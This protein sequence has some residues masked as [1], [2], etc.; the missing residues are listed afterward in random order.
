MTTLAE[1][2]IIAVAD[3]RPPMLEKS[4][5]DS[6]KCRM[7]HYMENRE[8]R[9]MILNLVQNGPLIW[10]TVTEEDGLVVLMFNQGD[11]P[12]DCLN[13]SMAFLTV[14]A[15][16]SPVFDDDETLIL[17]EVLLVMGERMQEDMQGLLSAIIVKTEDLD[18]YDSDCD[19]VS[20]TKA[21]LMANLSNYSS[22]VIL[23]KA[24][25]IK[26]T[27]Y[28]GSVISKQHVASPV[29]DDDETLILEETLK[30]IFNVF[31][32]DLLNE[33]TEVQT[34]FNQMEAAV[35]HESCVKCLNLDAKLLNKENEYN[36]L[37]KCYSQHEKHCISLE[38]TMKLNQE[39]FQMES[40]TNI[41]NALEILEY[42]ENNELKAQLQAK[43]TTIRKLKEH[44]KT[45]REND[46]EEKVK[47]EM[48]EIE[49]IN[50]ELEH[51]VAKLLFENERKETVKN[52][53]KI[54]IATTIS[55]GIF[56]LD[57][58]T[59][60]PRLLQNR[61]A[62]I[63]YLKHTSEQPD[64]LQGIVEQTKAKQPLDNALDHTCKHANQVDE[65]LVYV[66]DTC[67]NV[68]KLSE[69][70]VGITPIN[71]VKKVRF[72]KP[73]T[74]SSNIKQ[75]CTFDA[76]HDVGFLDFVNDVN[77]HDKFK[78]KSK[79]IQVHNIWKPTDSRYS[80]H[81]TGNRS[82][83]MNFVSKFLGTVRF[84]NDQVANIMGYGDYQ[85][86]NIII[87]R[88]YYVKGLRH[89]LFSVGQFCDADLEVA[90][91]KNTC[92]I[93][94]LEGVDLLLGSRDTNLYTISLDDMLKTSPI[95]NLSKASKTKSWLWHRRLSHLNFGTLNM[96]AKDGLAR[97][98]PNLNF[99]KFLR[100]KDEA[101]ESIIKCIKKFNEDSRK[102]NAK[103]DIGI[104]VGYV[105]AKKAFRI[106]N[107]RTQKTMETI[108]V[109]FD[110]LTTMAFEQFDSGPG[111]QSMTPTTTSS[112]LAPN[113]IP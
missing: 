27:L 32:K 16:L 20:N 74:S 110:E 18:A 3:N 111:L 89:N 98:I 31:D 53:A 28:D 96:L 77:M 24:Q 71:K 36:D 91:R 94:N 13:K 39:N 62:H 72:F 76:N 45:M 101:P 59:L 10:P 88:V 34:V 58:D 80:K 38:L 47:H 7:E 67:P 21:V 19:V 35:Q 41:Q 75:Q 30:D 87:L 57:L 51:S 106:Y 100:S 109:T 23:E 82:Q 90:F 54:A 46:K 86:G 92:F 43:D 84:E 6:W 49:T 78:S 50:L 33:V 14:I 93:R 69:K 22:D 105:P 56:K 95:C 25:R 60:A 61:E 68:I 70:K 107:R 85:L 112:G 37:L 44:I 12:I 26:L 81:M 104:F 4:L 8:N 65:L 83:L 64:M 42:F 99:R 1:Y 48:D 11:D 73:L 52:A 9:R 97:G 102:L 29:F 55:L 5:Y 113:T 108:H 79:K 63:Y 17:E 15:S 66:R 40:F 2:M 103:A